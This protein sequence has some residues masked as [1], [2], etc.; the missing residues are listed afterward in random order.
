MSSAGLVVVGASLAGL[1]AVEAARVTGYDGKI[2]LI[3][4]ERHSPYDRPPL[5]KAFLRDAEPVVPSL[6]DRQ[7]LSGLDVEVRLGQAADGLCTERREVAVGGESVPYDALVIAT[8]C[9]P[10][11]LPDT[12]GIPGVHSLRTLDDAHAIRERIAEGTRAVLIGGGFIGAEVATV[13]RARGAEVTIVE[14]AEVPL[15]RAV[16]RE[17]APA[18]AALHARAGVELCCGVS[19]RGVSDTPGGK[20]VEL[21][22]GSVLSADLVLV[23]IGAKPA[24]SWL[25]GS[26]VPVSDGVLC[27]ETLR[28]VPGVYAAGDVARWHNPLFGTT[29]RLENWTAAAELGGA[30]GRHAVRPDTAVPVSTVPYF[31]S[32]WYG[33][34]IQMVGVSEA[35]EVRVIGDPDSDSWAALYRT[36]DRVVGALTLNQPRRIMKYRAM[37]V[38]RASWD[39]ACEF[40]GAFAGSGGASW[41]CVSQPAARRPRLLRQ[42]PSFMGRFVPCPHHCLRRV[43]ALAQAAVVCEQP[44]RGHHGSAPDR[45]RRASSLVRAAGHLPARAAWLTLTTPPSSPR[46]RLKEAQ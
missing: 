3:G 7:T 8:G 39:T 43:V 12:G 17:M 20:R 2:T 13:L 32:D 25:S 21:T 34:R 27:D 15:V 36:G 19:V 26:G 33:S 18:L 41:H 30:A 14:A 45:V 24:T 16:G 5:S 6:T 23:G 31:W 10:T 40:A 22:D 1:R 29:M 42:R 35:D 11:A 9:T 46:P 44:H 4:A 38:R 28:A 37:I